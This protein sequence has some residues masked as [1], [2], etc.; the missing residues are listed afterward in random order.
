MSARCLSRP[1]IWV[2][3]CD[4]NFCPKFRVD[5]PRMGN[6]MEC[7]FTWTLLSNES[8]TISGLRIQCLIVL[9][10]HLK[11]WYR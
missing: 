9:F 2:L 10:N 6:F 8:H 1:R 11:E 5:L 3:G 7:P 4:T